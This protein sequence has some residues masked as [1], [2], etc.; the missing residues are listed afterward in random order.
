VRV[1]S[2]DCGGYDA[3]GIV[4]FAD[5]RYDALGARISGN[6]VTKN[7]VSLSSGT[8]AL[9]PV[10]GVELSDTRDLETEL[11]IKD[12]AVVY[13]DLRGLAVPVALTPDEL[14][15]VNRIEKNLTGPASHWPDRAI[16]ALAPAAAQASPS[17]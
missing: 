5:W 6:R 15:T 4:L 17:R 8:P 11:D 9:V 1:P 2:D 14:S 10:A 12:N 3:P 7:R 13:N 16:G